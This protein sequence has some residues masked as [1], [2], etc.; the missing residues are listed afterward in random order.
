VTQTPVEPPPPH[1]HIPGLPR[2]D[3]H[4]CDHVLCGI[5]GIPGRGDPDGNWV[6]DSPRTA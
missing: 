6:D 3:D 5:C 4:V 1:D 2:H